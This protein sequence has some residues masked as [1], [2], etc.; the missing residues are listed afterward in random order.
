[1]FWCGAS[2]T[3]I[4]ACWSQTLYQLLSFLTKYY[5]G[6]LDMQKNLSSQFFDLDIENPLGGGTVLYRVDSFQARAALT[7]RN[8]RVS[9]N[10]RAEL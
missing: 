9:K 10:E 1:M 7:N 3:G 5:F 2:K 6:H 8:S 4:L